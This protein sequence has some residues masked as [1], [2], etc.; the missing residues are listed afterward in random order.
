MSNNTQ[1]RFLT[2][3][4]G[5]VFSTEKNVYTKRNVDIKLFFVDTNPLI[6]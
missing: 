1:L 2:E 4:V 6:F 3:I 5:N